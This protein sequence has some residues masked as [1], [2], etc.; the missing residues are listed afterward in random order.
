MAIYLYNDGGGPKILTEGNA[1]AVHEDCCCDEGGACY[2]LRPCPNGDNTCNSCSPPISDIMYVTISGLGD[3]QVPDGDYAVTHLST[4]IW[5]FDVSGVGD[6]VIVEYI[7][8]N[9]LVRA[10][11]SGAWIYMPSPLCDPQGS[12]GGGQYVNFAGAGGDVSVSLSSSST[13]IFPTDI[14]VTDSVTPGQVIKYS[15]TCYEVIAEVPCPGTE[16]TMGTYEVFDSCEMC[17]DNCSACDPPLPSSFTL[18]IDGFLDSGYFVDIDGTFTCEYWGTNDFGDC[19]YF[20]ELADSAFGA[21]WYWALVNS[22]G[23]WRVPLVQQWR[24]W[25]CMPTPMLPF[26]AER[27]WQFR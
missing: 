27:L 26:S 24:L 10:G 9:W 11:G 14:V 17:L 22:G 20:S 4:C 23:S 15:G 2:L 12:T 16:I 3:P 25:G 13:T 6:L 7:G 8:G 18:E 21:D 5:S 19:Y 1:I